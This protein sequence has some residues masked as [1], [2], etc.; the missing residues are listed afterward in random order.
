MHAVTNEHHIG[1]DV[2]SVS[3]EALAKIC[4]VS[5]SAI[6]APDERLPDA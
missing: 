4:W 6:E 2:I 3:G 5:K 1:K